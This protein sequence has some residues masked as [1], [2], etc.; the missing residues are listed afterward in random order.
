MKTDF[1]YIIINEDFE[2]ALA[3]LAAV[4]TATRLRYE[5]QAASHHDLFAQ[6]GIP[7]G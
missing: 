3:Q 2:A 1:D 5:S 4:V 7:T 6:L